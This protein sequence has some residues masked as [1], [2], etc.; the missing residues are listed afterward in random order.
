MGLGGFAFIHWG[1]LWEILIKPTEFSCLTSRKITQSD[2]GKGSS[3]DNVRVAVRCRP[4][5]PKEIAEGHG[6]VVQVDQVRGQVTVHLP[7]PIRSGERSKSFTF[8]SVFGFDAKQVDIYNETARPIVDFVLEGYNGNYFMY[9][10]KANPQAS[11]SFSML[12]T[13]S[14]PLHTN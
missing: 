11:P 10:Y 9:I 2:G 7:N 4:L 13:E 6:A 1:W 3:D 8:D 5:S 14:L 12:H